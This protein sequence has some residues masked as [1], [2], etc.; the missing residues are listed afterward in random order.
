MIPSSRMIWVVAVV[1]FPA[2][3]LAALSPEARVVGV[4]CLAAVVVVILIDA[5]MRSR[6]LDGV[7]VELPE[8]VRIFKD[9]AGEIRVRVHSG[10]AR[11]V[12]IGVVV[13]DGIHAEAEETDV[14][15]PSETSEFI[16][17]WTAQRRGLYRVEAVYLEAFSPWGMWQVRRKDAAAM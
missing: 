8:L 9:R 4:V 5:S 7:R 17:K 1:G 16:W 3:T 15:L 11:R 6:A 13:P 10:S 2:A 12:R 14:E